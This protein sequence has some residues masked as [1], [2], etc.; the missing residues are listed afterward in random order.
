MTDTPQETP[1][2]SVAPS[3]SAEQTEELVRSL[4]RKEGSWVNWGKHCQTLQKAGYNPQQI[5]EETG[6]EPIHQ[7]QVIV[8]SQVYNSIV[9]V[10][11]S[12]ETRSHFERKGSDILY[13]L[14]I[15]DQ[16]QRAAAAQFIVSKNLDFDESHELAKAMKDFSRLS[17]LPQ[18]FS[19]HPGD[20]VAYQCWKV[21]RQKS[22]LQERSRS[23]A[24]G[25]SFAH[26]AIARQKIEQLL[27]D[28]TVTPE[29]SAP[30]L[31]VY[32]LES[33]N[34]LPRILPVVGRMP[35][36][37]ED[38]QAVP[39]VEEEGSFRMIKTSGNAA[40]VPV[41]SWQV[42][43]QAEDPVAI[44]CSSDEAPNPLPGKPEE[45]LMVIDRR[46]R[47][48]D[49]NSYFIFD[50][51]EKLQIQWFEEKP[52]T[53]LLGKVILVLRPKKVLDEEYNKEPWQID[54]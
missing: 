36:T 27:T 25:L 13:E 43:L 40:C 50:G 9:N 8:G 12:E 52:D 1:N 14:R 37:V 11:V 53:R 24:R 6:F 17:Q 47:E 2:P 51:G 38:L 22:D 35:L 42:I 20:A 10:G 30:T 26:S 19:K 45:V 39:L 32:R 41:P 48:W 28:F 29:R 18:G 33:A 5:F 31:P 49:A 15:L 21:A 44:L 23:I 16:E 3:L 4:R 7:N 54:E 34:E 46:H